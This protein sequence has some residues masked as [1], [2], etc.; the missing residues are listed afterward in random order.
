METVAKAAKVDFRE[1]GLTGLK[2]MGG[3]VY[4]EFLPQLSGQKE[5]IDGDK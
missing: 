5:Y 2:R 4:E 1:F 3:L